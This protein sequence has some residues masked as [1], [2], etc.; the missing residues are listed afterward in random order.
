MGNR[1]FA[2][3]D[4]AKVVAQLWMEVARFAFNSLPADSFVLRIR[5]VLIQ[6][7]FSGDWM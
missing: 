4:N 5:Q 6:P 2:V 7:F 1:T 3:T